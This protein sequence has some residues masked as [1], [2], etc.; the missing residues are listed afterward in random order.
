[1]VFVVLG[2]VTV[3]YVV[4]GYCHHTNICMTFPALDYRVPLRKFYVINPNI[5]ATA[6]EYITRF[7]SNHPQTGHNNTLK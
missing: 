5:G 3:T 4:A 7:N 1:M 2:M 6:L